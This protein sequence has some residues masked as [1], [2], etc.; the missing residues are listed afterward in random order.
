MGDEK[1]AETTASNKDGAG[2]RTAERALVGYLESLEGRP[3][4][5]RSRE[6]YGHQGATV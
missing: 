1:R 5:A 6:A 4:A 2:E 3:L